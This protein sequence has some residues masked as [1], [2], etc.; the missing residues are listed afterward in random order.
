MTTSVTPT[1]TAAPA[2]CHACQR[3]MNTP[4]FCD[5]CRNLYPAEGLTH[6]EMLGFTPRYDLDPAELRQR[7]LQTSR[8]I[9][10]DSFSGSADTGLSVRLC[11]QLN[12]V[13]RVL[14]DPVLRAEYLLEISG[15]QSAAQDKNVPPEVLTTALTLREELEAAREADDQAR[16]DAVAGV[17]VRGDSQDDISPGPIPGNQRSRS[18]QRGDVRGRRDL[19]PALAGGHPQ[20]SGYP[21]GEG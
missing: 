8:D 15:G 19:Q 18:D 9:H 5:H 21:D 14:S 2:K 3:P 7:Y 10:P 1:G 20:D 11:A 16:C 13:Y 12:E 17:V 4:L 6:F